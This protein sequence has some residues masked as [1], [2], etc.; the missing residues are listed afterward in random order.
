VNVDER[1]R[2]R[3]SGNS[4]SDPQLN[5]RSPLC[6]VCHD[7]GVLLATLWLRGLHVIW[8]AT[9]LAHHLTQQTHSL[10]K[11]GPGHDLIRPN[12]NRDTVALMQACWKADCR[13]WPIMTNVD[14]KIASSDTISIGHGL[15]SMKHQRLPSQRNPDPGS[16]RSCGSV[17]D[18][19][20]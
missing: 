17:V 7:D 10:L 8:S 15:D 16:R 19:S 9:P 1:H 18:L 11:S 3:E 5:V 14:R 2:P 12:P 13:F 20:R 6:P 4:I